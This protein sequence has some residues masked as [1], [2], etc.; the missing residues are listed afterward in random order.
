MEKNEKKQR[1]FKILNKKTATFIVP[2]ITSAIDSCLED[3]EWVI[4]TMKTNASMC[5][6]LQII[7]H[8]YLFKYINFFFFFLLF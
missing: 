6:E 2:C 1:K 5:G 4:H 8:L 3:V 7:I